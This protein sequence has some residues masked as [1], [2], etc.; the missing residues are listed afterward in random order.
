MVDIKNIPALLKTSCRF[1]VELSPPCF[2][3][4]IWNTFGLSHPSRR[5]EWEKMNRVGSSK[6]NSRSLF[7]RMRS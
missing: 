6:D 5:A 4:Q 1:C 7:F 2:S 3:V